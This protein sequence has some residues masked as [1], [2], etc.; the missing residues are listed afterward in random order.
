MRGVAALIVLGAAGLLAGCV[1]CADT[2]SGVITQPRVEGDT[3]DI[4]YLRRQVSGAISS[5]LQY[6]ADSCRANERGL[7]AVELDVDLRSGRLQGVRLKESS[8][9]PRLDDEMMRAWRKIQENGWRFDLPPQLAGRHGV[10]KV[11]FALQFQGR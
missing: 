11:P 3:P 9:H 2:R 1:S 6:P 10:L 8:G 5:E 4:V 7:V